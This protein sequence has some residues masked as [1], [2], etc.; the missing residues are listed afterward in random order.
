[1]VNNTPPTGT[2]VF[3]KALPP[4]DKI[5]SD[6]EYTIVGDNLV[7]KL[8][9]DNL[10][11]FEEIYLPAGLTI[12]DMNK[13]SLNNIAII[14][15][16]TG[17]DK[18]INIPRNKLE[19]VAGEVK[20]NKFGIGVNLGA[21]PSDTDFST[22]EA[23]LQALCLERFGVIIKTKV[24]QLSGIRSLTLEEH[25]NLI[26]S[27]DVVSRNKFNIFAQNNF[28]KTELERLNVLNL[29][30]RTCLINKQ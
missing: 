11:P 23:E 14:T 4:F 28:L 9:Q 20:Y 2:K 12:D 6:V 16:T 30:F 24:A 1:M 10:N 17:S 19:F 3:V 5:L 8:I 25:N 7:S 26:T 15:F 21:L 22:F 18:T 27:R 13:D 29:K